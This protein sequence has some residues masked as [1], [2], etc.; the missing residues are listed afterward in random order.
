MLRLALFRSVIS[1]ETKGIDEQADNLRSARIEHN[2]DISTSINKTDV[3]TGRQNLSLRGHRHDS[4]HYFSANSGSS[5]KFQ[6]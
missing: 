1:G 5:F 6:S 3:L 2:R 4:T